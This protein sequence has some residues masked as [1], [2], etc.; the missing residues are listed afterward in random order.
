MSK[1]ISNGITLDKV[2]GLEWQQIDTGTVYTFNNAKEYCRE[3]NL[4]GKS[5]FSRKEINSL[6]P[7][8][9]EISSSLLSVDNSFIVYFGE[10]NSRDKLELILVPLDEE[11]PCQ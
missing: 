7:H 3:L 9:G 8:G 6:L 11:S 1:F 5:D 4:G 2:T 10:L